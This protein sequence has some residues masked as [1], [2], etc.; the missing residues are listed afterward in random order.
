MKGSPRMG[1]GW[2]FLKTFRVSLFNEDLSNEPNFSL[3]STVPLTVAVSGNLSFSFSSLVFVSVPLAGRYCKKN[4]ALNV[5][6]TNTVGSSISRETHCGVHINAGPEVGVA[7]TKAYTS[8]VGPVGVASTKAYTSQVGPVGVAS[9]KACT[10]Q[11]GPVGV[12]STKSYTSQVGQ[13]GMAST[14]VYTSQ[15]GPVG[16]AS[17]KA[18]TSSI[19]P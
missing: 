7:S 4:G 16:V 12:A 10:S 17:T 1:G 19:N 13:V 9:T 8:Q 18:Y 15:V 11:V 3:E 14:K 5:G 6:I 2:I